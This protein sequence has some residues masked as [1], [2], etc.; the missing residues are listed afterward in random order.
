MVNA[1]HMQNATV[2]RSIITTPPTVF[3][4][5]AIIAFA[6]LCSKGQVRS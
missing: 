4:C 3:G 2:K 6:L 1:T 5:G